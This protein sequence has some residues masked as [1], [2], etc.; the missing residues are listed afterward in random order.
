[1]R[2]PLL[3][4]LLVSGCAS[5]TEPQG[6]VGHYTLETVS[7]HTLPASSVLGAYRGGSL[8]LRADST[9]VDVLI[10]GNVVDS[11]FGRYVVNADSIRMTPS[12]WDHR[13]AVHR[14]GDVIRAQWGE[15]IF[16]YRRD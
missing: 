3:V 6:D 11:V 2:L 14:A 4:V 13:Y 15:G 10:L 1:M 8:E 5:V 7:G 12:N 16:L 9:F